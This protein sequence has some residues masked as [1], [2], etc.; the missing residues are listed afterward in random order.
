[1]N[2]KQLREK[3]HKERELLTPTERQKYSEEIIEIFLRNYQ[4]ESKLVSIFLPIER[5]LEINTYKL[6]DR[7][8]NLNAKIAL[9]KSNFETTEMEQI[10]FSDD[11]RLKTNKWGI[12]EPENGELISVESIDIV[13]VPLLISDKKG[14]RVGYGKGFYD[15]FLEKCKPNC[16]FVGINYFE[17]I[18]KIEDSNSY[19]IKLDALITPKGI[20]KY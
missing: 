19:D 10:L 18:E 1:M 3:F 9:S 8:K 5:K 20:K 2:K 6:L 17:P 13:I 14:N 12:P 16:Q 4:I 15:R 11:V 7:L